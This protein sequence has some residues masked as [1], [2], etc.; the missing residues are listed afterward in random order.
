MAREIQ[1][2]GPR[3]TQKKK[4]KNVKGNLFS[5]ERG[6]DRDHRRLTKDERNEKN[7][8]KTPGGH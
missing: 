2:T 5:R 1:S 6:K 8:E 7:G 4:R 3:K